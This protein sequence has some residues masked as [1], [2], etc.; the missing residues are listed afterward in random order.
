MNMDE[1]QGFKT[2]LLIRRREGRSLLNS[3]GLSIGYV[4]VMTMMCTSYTYTRTE[5]EDREKGASTGSWWGW[6][7]LNR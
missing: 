4:L 2:G 1:G 7:H 3:V 6:T 5:D